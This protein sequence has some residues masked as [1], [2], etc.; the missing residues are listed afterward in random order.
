MDPVVSTVFS[1]HT[2]ELFLSLLHFYFH[3]NCNLV[4]HH[5]TRNILVRFILGALSQYQN[6]TRSEKV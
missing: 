4:D 3:N 2:S 5:K 6:Q 1:I